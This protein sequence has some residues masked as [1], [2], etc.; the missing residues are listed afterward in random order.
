MKATNY[1]LLFLVL[2]TTVSFGQSAG[3]QEI[4]LTN[5]EVPNSPA[6]MLLDVAPTIIERPTSGKAFA[7]S[8]LN[9]V[10]EN[11]GIPQNYAV[12]LTP[13]WYFKHPDLNAF[14]YWG[15]DPKTN[16]N[17]GFNQIK[18]ANISFAYA[19]TKWPDTA[20][21]GNISNLALGIRGTIFQLISKSNRKSL[22][23]ANNKVVNRLSELNAQI[24]QFDPFDEDYREKVQAF[25]NGMSADEELLESEQELQE[26]LNRKPLF[27][28][29]GAT[30]MNWSFD[31]NNFSTNRLSLFGAWLTLDYS[32]E[33]NPN[34]DAHRNYLSFL[35]L[36]RYTYD[37]SFDGN[38]IATG[39]FMNL[40][41]LGGKIEFEFKQLS[42]SYEYIFRTVSGQK[43]NTFRST[44][45][46]M[47]KVSD[48]IYLLASL[49][50]NF[51]D[52]NNLIAQ[53][54]INLGFGTGNEKV[55]TL[56]K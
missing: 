40:F 43:A 33:L 55:W 36:A 54:G 20:V 51:G 10:N 28:I 44:G 31:G 26:I 30:A 6:F 50:K 15:I 21:P 12:E 24:A 2:T 38:P 23:A 35:M 9:T 45:M 8:I 22:L 37:N 32:Q 41:D 48:K 3:N 17:K 29:D 13:Y 7:M 49:G 39:S 14:K 16:K 53:F 52:T 5:L 47:Y 18:Q 19:N 56:K 34:N 25:L 1:F 42:F 11:N 27:A 4:D 46:A